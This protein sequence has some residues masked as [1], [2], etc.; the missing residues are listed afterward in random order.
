MDEIVKEFFV[1]SYE[2]LDRIDRDPVVLEKYPHAKET[3]ARIFRTI[4]TLTGSSGFS[5][6]RKTGSCSTCR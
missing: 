4:H 1:E 5:W 2:S 6:F 3:L